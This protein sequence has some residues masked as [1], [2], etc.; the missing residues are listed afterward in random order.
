MITAPYNF[1]P[2]NNEVFYPDWDKDISHD[3]PF[4]D[5][6]SGIIDIEIIAKSPIFIRNHYEDGDEYYTS[7]NGDKISKE[8]CNVKVNGGKQY[9]I[10]GTSIK[11]M[12]RSVLEI[13]SFSK[14]TFMQDKTLNVRDMT[15]QRELV[16]GGKGCGFLVQDGDTYK[17]EDC[18]KP[19]SISFNEVKKATGKSIRN[20]KTAKE[21]YQAIG[22]VDIPVKEDKKI[23]DVYGKKISK[24]IALFDASSNIKVRLVLTGTINN[25]KNEFVFIKNDKTID[26]DDIVVKKF[27]LAY[28]HEDSIDGKYWEKQ[29]KKGEKIPVFYSKDQSG[30]INQIGLTQLFKLAYNKS[31]HEAAKQNT[32]ENRFDLAQCIFGI[33]NEDNALKG[34]VQFSHMKSSHVTFEKEK[35]EILGEPNPTYYPNY[36]RQNNVHGDKVKRYK[37]LM[38]SDAE[39]SGW[40]RY[41]LHNTIV[42]SRGGNDNEDVRSRFK[43]LDTGSKFQGKI[44]FHNLKKAE[45][46]ALISALTFHG[47]EQSHMHNIGMAKSLGYGKISLELRL[48]TY[49]KYTKKEYLEAFEQSITKEIPDWGDS[50]QLTELFA[51]SSINCKSNEELSYQL[52]ENPNPKYGLDKKRAESNDFT[53]AKKEKEYLLPHSAKYVNI[54]KARITAKK[55]PE[56]STDDLGKLFG[57]TGDIKKVKKIQKKSTSSQDYARKGITVVKKVDNGTMSNRGK[58]IP[59]NV[60]KPK[61]YTIKEIADEIKISVEEVVEFANSSTLPI[62]KDITLNSTLKEA[63]AKGL[64]NAIKKSRS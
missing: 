55:H 23:M 16:G 30:K 21:K 12:T 13:L 38:D 62:P 4:E 7:K 15:N 34:R 58:Q 56:N 5:G 32:K 57:G 24:D 28:F 51:M 54:N 44:R 49:L 63:Q 6:E 26:L 48:S 47:Q 8:F 27:K 2:L 41:P 52:L 9:Y 18:G 39:I 1:V 37:T 22:M 42:A 45:I 29:W 64:I 36:I 20:M 61:I 10:P 35:S 60:S 43:P 25:K 14:I 59:L 33:T 40:K 46:G 11:G 17:I 50:A 31:L 3:V 53:G 19:R